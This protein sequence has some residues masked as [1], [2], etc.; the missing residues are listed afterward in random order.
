MQQLN[1]HSPCASVRFL[2]QGATLTDNYRHRCV[3]RRTIQ[4]TSQPNQEEPLFT[5]L[6]ARNYI[7]NHC[8]V[9][10][11]QPTVDPPGDTS[12][13]RPRTSRYF[14][15]CALGIPIKR[16]RQRTKQKPPKLQ[17]VQVVLLSRW[18]D[19]DNQGG[20]LQEKNHGLRF[21]LATTGFVCAAI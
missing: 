19:A 16:D 12:T 13:H 10:V 11:T 1:R 4:L 6:G 14:T 17:V 7:S 20:G 15:R 9:S 2:N 3:R 5:V 21:V 8:R 18:N